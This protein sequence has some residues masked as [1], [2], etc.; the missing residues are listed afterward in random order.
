MTPAETELHR[1]ECEA[2][3]HL[4]MPGAERK[5]ALERIE[6]IRGEAAAKVL[7]DDIRRLRQEVQA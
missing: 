2:R 6:K 7:A 3:H 5:A 4:R 1:R